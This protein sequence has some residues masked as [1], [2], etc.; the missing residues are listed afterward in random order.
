[1]S[2]IELQGIG[3]TFRISKR[4]EGRMGVL[5]GAFV[6]ETKTIAA[7]NGDASYLDST[8]SWLTVCMEVGVEI[9][10]QILL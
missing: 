3:K 10:K 2:Q 5:K 4:P 6:R 9:R 8:A 7:L 1:M